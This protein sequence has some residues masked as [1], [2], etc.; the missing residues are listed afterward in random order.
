MAEPPTGG[1]AGLP[2]TGGGAG[3]PPTEGGAD[4]PPA[5]DRTGVPKALVTP[6]RR[7]AISLVWVI[8]LLA[9]LVG[10]WVIWQHFNSQG[11]TIT[12][13]FKNAEGIEANKTKVRYKDVDIGTVTGT[14]ISADRQQVIITAQIAKR[15]ENLILDDTRFWVVRPRIS[16]NT[17][18]GLST[19]LSGAYIDVDAGKSDS[20]RQAFTGLE[21]PPPVTS[22]TAGRL[23]VLH[24]D[25]I[26]SLYIGAPAYYRRVPVGNVTGYTLDRDG[27]GVT[28][29]IFVSAPNDALVTDNV[30][31]WHA[32]GIDASIEASGIKLNTESIISVLVGGIAFESL[33]DTPQ[34]APAAAG[35]TFRLYGDRAAALKNLTEEVHTYLLYFKESL[36]GLAPSAP[37]DF[38]GIVIGEVRAVSV[39]YDR[40][41]KVLRFPVEIAIF[42][43]RMRSRYRI[44]GPELSAMERNPRI[45]LDQ[46]VSRGFRAQLKSAN[47]I[48]GQLYVALDLFPRAAPARIDWNHKPVVLP[49]VAAPLE[50]IQETI[51]NI[52]RKLDKVPFDAIGTD[53]D[54]TLKTLNQTLRSADQVVGRLNS[55]ILPELQGTLAQARQALGNADRLLAPDAPVQDNLQQTLKEV[56]RAAQALRVLTDYLSRHPESLIRGKKEAP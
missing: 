4:G 44:G 53:L 41:A 11:P 18:S 22:D 40:E 42:P 29:E 37:V 21:A 23:F 55:A 46:M 45:L 1:G 25:N 51:G 56:T 50:D 24:A 12:I 2:P 38:H 5:G 34:G 26:G 10:A 30:R 15:S 7:R 3:G 31:F 43:E 28:L 32:S 17:I 49:T 52:A 36:R 13:A 54:R 39:E 9:A 14:S 33:P 8:P 48:T 20:R 27:K 6:R 19:L 47:L 16:V 35:A